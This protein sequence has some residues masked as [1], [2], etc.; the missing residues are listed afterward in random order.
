MSDK[1]INRF[2]NITLNNL[3]EWCTLDKNNI[4][5][6]DQL[7]LNDLTLTAIDNILNYIEKPTPEKLEYMKSYI[8][9]I[10]CASY[11]IG[12]SKINESKKIIEDGEEWKNCV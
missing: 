3:L 5:E 1:S 6:K 4:N 12:C 8:I 10:V 9:A 7:F 2:K 11:N